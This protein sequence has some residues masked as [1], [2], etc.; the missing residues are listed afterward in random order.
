MNEIELRFIC[1]N[2]NHSS[3]TQ[4]SQTFHTVPWGPRYC[5][6]PSL[7]QTY[8]AFNRRQLHCVYKSHLNGARCDFSL[9]LLVSSVSLFAVHKQIIDYIIVFCSV[10][11][12]GL[13]SLCDI[14]FDF[15]YIFIAFIRAQIHLHWTKIVWEIHLF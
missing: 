2:S 9:L 10:H 7:V 14:V 1:P 6:T 15:Y 12:S 13:I 8:S 3:T 11:R 4:L 5:L